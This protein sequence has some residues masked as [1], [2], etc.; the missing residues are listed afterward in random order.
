MPFES[1]L[2]I[3]TG[4]VYLVLT[5]IVGAVLLALAAIDRPAPFIVSVEHGHMGFVG[6]LVNMVIGVAFWMFPLD[7]ERFPEM[8]GR[9]PSRAPLLCYYLLNIG[10]VMRLVLEPAAQLSSARN[11]LAIPVAASGVLQLLAIFIFVGIIWHR[12]RGPKHPAPGV[13]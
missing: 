9:Y 7:R 2:F 3:K 1:R 11:V 5:F 4:A 12:T 10:L 6:W 13:R 8:Q